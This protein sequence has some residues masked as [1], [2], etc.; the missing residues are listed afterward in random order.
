MELFIKKFSFLFSSLWEKDIE[1]VQ[2]VAYLFIE[3][4]W[5]MALDMT[6][7]SPAACRKY[8]LF[9]KKEVDEP[10]QQLIWMLN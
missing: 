5:A 6:N 4:N 1:F 7:I 8:L 2:K 9:D 10:Q 3:M